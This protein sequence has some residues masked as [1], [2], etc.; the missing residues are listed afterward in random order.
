MSYADGDRRGR[1]ESSSSGT[2]RPEWVLGHR[3]RWVAT[4]IPIRGIIVEVHRFPNSGPRDGSVDRPPRSLVGYDDP[5]EYA[6]GL[7]AHVASTV[8]T[9][10]CTPFES[11]APP[12]CREP[13]HG[14][15]RQS[16][17]DCRDCLPVRSPDIARSIPERLPT[18]TMRRRRSPP[19]VRGSRLVRRRRALDRAAHRGCF[20][21]TEAT[22]AFRNEC[23]CREST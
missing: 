9:V 12:W 13:S 4:M 6:G 22:D 23:R 20:A 5:Y 8:D 16:D 7:P 15:S 10:G 1:S 2:E 3:D 11:I 17:S 19:V 21:P 18:I 14:Y